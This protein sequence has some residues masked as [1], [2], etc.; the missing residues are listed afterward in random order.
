MTD[1]PR[2]SDP[3][4]MRPLLWLARPPSEPRETLLA[5]S[6][7][8]LP[9]CATLIAV[10][11]FGWTW[12]I[13]GEV[14]AT[15]EHHGVRDVMIAVVNETAKA[16]ALIVLYAVSITYILDIAGG[17]IV[18]TAR[19]LTEKLVEPL[20]ERLR[21]EGREEGLEQGREEGRSQGREEGLEEGLE[22]GRKQTLDE[23]SRKLAEWNSRREAAKKKGV[24][25][26]EPPP[27][28]SYPESD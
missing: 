5:V 28:F 11:T 17:T 12:I 21:E 10:F 15:A 8:W 1:E 27:A 14:V 13:Y 24:P 26:D 7:K 9:F 20:R 18:V 2:N 4:W 25:F 6:R 16:A 23:V 22:R 3:L 19:Y